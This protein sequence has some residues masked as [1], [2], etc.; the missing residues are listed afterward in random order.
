[1]VSFRQEKHKEKP[2]KTTLARRQVAEY[3]NPFSGQ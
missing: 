1:M 3:F 2:L